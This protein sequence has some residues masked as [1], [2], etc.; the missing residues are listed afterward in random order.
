MKKSKMDSA[1]EWCRSWG[2][3]SGSYFF[4]AATQMLFAFSSSY[5]PELGNGIFY[6]LGF[7]AIVMGFATRGISF[8]Q[9]RTPD[10]ATET[11]S[12]FLGISQ[13]T[14]HIG[15]CLAMIGLAGSSMKELPAEHVYWAY[16]PM[17]TGAIAGWL[18]SI[19]PPRSKS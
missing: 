3:A 11:R 19:A 15:L 6:L 13:R 7:F 8:D 2:P 17:V 14:F 12:A 16:I 10:G 4:L 5:A 9:R 1:K 18:A